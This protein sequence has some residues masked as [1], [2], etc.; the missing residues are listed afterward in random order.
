MPGALQGVDRPAGQADVLNK[1]ENRG[2]HLKDM[3]PFRVL[4]LA[5]LTN[6][7]VGGRD[8]EPRAFKIATLLLGKPEPERKAI[9]LPEMD[10]EALVGVYENADGQARYITREGSQVFSQS[11][12]S[13]TAPEK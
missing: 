5:I 2:A 6:S 13:R 11:S 1:P 10:I 3:S 12:S 4:F 9:T 7:T 8:P